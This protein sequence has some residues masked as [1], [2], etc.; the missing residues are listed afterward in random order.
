MQKFE[1]AKL[2]QM[3]LSLDKS[4]VYQNGQNILLEKD[5]QNDVHCLPALKVSGNNFML[6]IQ[7]I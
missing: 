1:T 6:F 5:S 2:Y 3:Q 7:N 4:E